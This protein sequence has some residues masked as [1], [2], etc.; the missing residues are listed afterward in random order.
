MDDKCR[1][2][3]AGGEGASV[4]RENKAKVAVAQVMKTTMVGSEVR[5]AKSAKVTSAGGMR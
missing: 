1:V 3:Y 2:G 4:P 5:Q